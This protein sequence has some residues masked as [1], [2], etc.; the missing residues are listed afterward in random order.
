MGALQAVRSNPTFPYKTGNLKYNA[1]YPK[2]GENFFS[3]VFD[4][5]IAPY[6]DFLEKGVPAQ[7]YTRKDGKSV[8]TR[9][10]MKHVGFIS[11]RATNDVIT[12]L[13]TEFKARVGY[14]VRNNQGNEY[15]SPTLS[16]QVEKVFKKK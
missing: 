6:I 5:T 2:S 10:S 15:L 11:V 16:R 14:I 8:F 12:Y 4:K 13:A 9:G 1:T 3:I 7:V